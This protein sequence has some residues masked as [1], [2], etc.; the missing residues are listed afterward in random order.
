MNFCKL[1]ENQF[2]KTIKRIRCDNGG[3]FTSNIMLNLYTKQGILL[4]T[5]CLHTP[6]QNGVVE[7]KH[8]HLLDTAQALRFEANL[9]KR[10]WREC[11]LTSAYIINRLASKI[12]GKKAPYELLHNQK[13]EYDHMRVFGCLT[14][15]WSIETKGDKMEAM[16]RPGIF[17]GYPQ[18]KK[19]YKFFDIDSKKMVVSRDLK[20]HEDTFTFPVQ[21]QASKDDSDIFIPIQAQ[22]V[23]EPDHEQ[24]TVPN[25]VEDTRPDSS[26]QNLGGH[27]MDDDG[28]DPDNTQE[29]ILSQ[30]LETHI[31]MGHSRPKRDRMQPKQ[32]DD[33]IVDLPPSIDHAHTTSTQVASTVHPISNYLSYKIFSKTHKTFLAA[34]TTNDEP[35]NFKQAIQNPKWIEAMKKEIQALEQNDTWTIKS[36]PE[37]KQAID[38]KWVYKIKYKP[39]G[40][41][42]RY[43]A[44][45]VTKG[46]T[47]IE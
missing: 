7:R 35:K 1:I 42:E 16:G 23:E 11:V 47:Q 22:D 27:I 44:R 13:P 14:Y 8:R 38:S 6:Q 40:D 24:V 45:L 9:P 30:N 2:N 19:G 3:E 32:L 29:E 12:L 36:L 10:F 15:F 39:N 20:F 31:D 25:D 34:I 26:P 5:T 33:F 17:L 18:G 46:F 28:S 21:T 43:K 4:E 41:I 37:G